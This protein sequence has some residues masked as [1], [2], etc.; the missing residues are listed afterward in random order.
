MIPLTDN[1]C[2]GTP[3]VDMV[4]LPRLFLAL[5]NGINNRKELNNDIDFFFFRGNDGFHFLWM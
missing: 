1:E 2:Y 4:D 3:N 5:S